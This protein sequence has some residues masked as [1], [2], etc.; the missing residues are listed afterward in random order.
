[1]TI[2]FLNILWDACALKHYFFYYMGNKHSSQPVQRPS[3]MDISTKSITPLYEACR[4]GNEEQV[5]NLLPKYSHADLN[6]QD[7]PYGGNTCLHVA[8]AN[9]HD[10]I[11]KL[12]LKHGSYRSSSLNSQNQSAYDLAVSKESM[13]SLFQRQDENN[14]SRFYE[15]SVSECFDIVTVDDN[16]DEKEKNQLSTTRSIVQTFRTEEEKQHE[17]EYSASSK[18]MC[19]SRFCRFFVNRLHSD[20]PLDYHTIIKRLN[21]LLEENLLND[22]VDY[23]K[24]NQL[25]NQYMKHYDSIEQLL[26]LYTLETQFYRVLKRDPLPLAIPLFMNLPKLKERYFK[27]R[28]YRGVHMTSDQLLT[29]QIAMDTSGTLL[30]TKSFSSTSMDRHIAEQFVSFKRITSEKNFCVLFIF[31]FPEICDQAINLSRISIDTPCLSE[32][33]DEKEILILPYTLF[34]VTRIRKD[35]HDDDF[36]TINL[37]NVIIPNKNLPATFKWT[38]VELKNQFIKDKKL[39]FDCAFQKHKQ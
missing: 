26:H 34:E 31:D 8:T 21:N 36:Y 29:Y 6:R 18:A 27:G 28:S 35:N 25:M 16:Q 3:E 13:R 10:N 4:D 32:Y 23:I 30:Q 11:V 39:K 9:G 14:P 19:Q 2:A 12:L 33:E 37:T 5:R 15:Q 38:W 7:F 22:S 17:I 24:A 1:M 20:E